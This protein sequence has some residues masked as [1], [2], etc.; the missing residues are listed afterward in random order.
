MC[1]TLNKICTGE[2]KCRE[3]A[4][5]EGGKRT[6]EALKY[7]RKLCGALVDGIRLQKHWDE[8]GV[9][10]MAQG[11]E[12][13]QL[14]RMVQKQPGLYTVGTSGKQEFWHSTGIRIPNDEEDDHE[15]RKGMVARDDVNGS[16]LGPNMVQQARREEIAYYNKM[17]VYR[18]VPLEECYTATGESPVGVR[19]IDHTE[20]D[21]LK[22]NYRP[23]LVGQDFNDGK[24]EELFAATPLLESLRL[25]LSH[26]VTG[27]EPR[28]LLIAHVSRAYTYA[29]CTAEMYVKLC[30]EDIEDESDRGKCRKLVKAMY[31]TRP[32]ALS[33]QTD[34]TNRL[35][36]AGFI[37]G[38]PYPC[39]FHYAVR[40]LLVFVHGDDFVA[41]GPPRKSAGL[42]RTSRASTKSRASQLV[43]ARDARTRDAY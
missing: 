42:E 15:Y 32:A 2:N 20:G 34:Y 16:D 6:R 36:A 37:V 40:K 35:T 13:H 3:H 28:E 38:L 39:V 23:R 19:W 41:A 33:W 24:H 1:N 27:D 7:H 8:G 43:K 21:R 31:G 14:G 30:E 18:T 29:D 9:G 4:W 26:A 22:P 25:V 17:G 11:F 12:V 5:L 10:M